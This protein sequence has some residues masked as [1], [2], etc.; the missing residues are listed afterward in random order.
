MSDWDGR[1]AVF[2]YPL[3]QMRLKSEISNYL[4]INKSENFSSKM[5]GLWP[6]PCSEENI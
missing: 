5:Y 3:D 1:E 6:K 4:E 2:K